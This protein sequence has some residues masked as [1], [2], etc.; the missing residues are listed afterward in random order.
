MN[1]NFLEYAHS[2]TGIDVGFGKMILVYQDKRSA[3]DASQ[4]T[5][6]AIQANIESGLIIG[7][8]KG[9]HT[10]AGAPVAEISVER[11][12]TA[13]M[14]L[15]RPE[16][17]ADVLTFESGLASNEVLADLV[18]AG[19]LNCILIDDQG[20]CFGDYSATADCISTMLCN[21][22]SKVVSGM[23]GT[24]TTE[25]TAAVTVRYLVKDLSICEAGTETEEIVSKTLLVGQLVSATLLVAGHIVLTLKDK[26]TNEYFTENVLAMGVTIKGTNAA[27]A[28][29]VFDESTNTYD[30]TFE[31]P[32][33][34]GQYQIT[35]SGET[36]Y[37]KETTFAIV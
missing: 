10:V 31:D 16:I 24:N 17:L 26:A 8:I 19:S 18:K 21:F 6:E 1:G 20:N 15:I 27:V 13:E 5:V 29:V 11:T 7:I 37:M 36:F 28:T 25:K 3:I 22:S 23:Q 33:A 4:L 9:W 34:A 12:G 2:K 14:K 30:I 35:I 32:I